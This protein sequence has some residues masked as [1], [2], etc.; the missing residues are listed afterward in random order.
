MDKYS[1][2]YTIA[3]N[4]MLDPTISLL[5]NEILVEFA[6]RILRSLDS[7]IP[8]DSPDLDVLVSEFVTEKA[9]EPD[10]EPEQEEP[11]PDPEPE[12]EPEFRLV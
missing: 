8:G 1:T 2:L 11:E 5:P 9:L 4:I 12:Q 7:M 3:N 6:K 10:P